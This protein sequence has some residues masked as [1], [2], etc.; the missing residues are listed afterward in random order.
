MTF[1]IAEWFALWQD[2]VSLVVTFYDAECPPDMV[3]HLL[4]EFPWGELETQLE[5]QYSHQ[6]A[7]S[8]VATLPEPVTPSPSRS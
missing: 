1:Y 5:W 7:Y 3:P 8:A 6:T 4:Y 2:P